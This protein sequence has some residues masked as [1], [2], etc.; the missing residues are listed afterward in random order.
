MKEADVKPD[1]H[2]F[3]H[4]IT[5]CNSEEDINMYYEEMKRSGIQVTKQVFMA[6]VN[7]Y[8]A[9]GQFEKAKQVSLLLATLL[10]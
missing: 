4:L 2:T 7:A 6:L 10:Y 1:S 3:S 9:C 5:N 8:A